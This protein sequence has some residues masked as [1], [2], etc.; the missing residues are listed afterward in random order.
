MSELQFFSQRS[1]KAIK[2]S[3]VYIF[4]V[5]IIKGSNILFNKPANIKKLKR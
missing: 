3:K 5:I 2:L 1:L 4:S